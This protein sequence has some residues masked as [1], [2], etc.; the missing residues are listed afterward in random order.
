MKWISVALLTL[1]LTACSGGGSGG[2]VGKANAAAAAC[3][4]FVKIK[5]E[6]KQFTLDQ[7]VLA[8][9]LKESAGQAGTLSSPIV[10]EPGLTTEV[11]QTI[12]C[13]VR[14]G[15]DNTPEVTNVTFIW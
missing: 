1:V 2:A 13:D 4:A 7:K 8:A 14:F 6:G 12:K 10:I 5:L 11:K 9:S 15:A 3:D